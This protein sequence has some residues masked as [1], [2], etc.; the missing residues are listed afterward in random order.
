MGCRDV[1]VGRRGVGPAE[2]KSTSQR[3]SDFCPGDVPFRLERPV[4]IAD[5]ERLMIHRVGGRRSWLR[6]GRRSWLRSGCRN[7][8]RSWLGSGLRPG[9]WHRSRNGTGIERDCG[10]CECS[11]I[12]YRTG[13]HRNEGLI[14]YISIKDRCRSKC[15][16]A[17]DLPEDVAGLGTAAQENL[18]GG[19]DIE[20]LPYLEDPDI[21]CATRKG[22]IRWYGN[23]GAPLI[24]ARGE[25]HPTNITSTQFDNRSGRCHSGSSGVRGFHVTYSRRHVSWS[26][27]SI[28]G[29]ICF[30][31]HQS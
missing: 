9:S 10:L 25:C 1:R 22:D 27:R 23:P 15:R 16:L 29:C 19:A 5:E 4:W 6:S 7:W 24:D 26:R 28:V 30:S 12:Q 31:S 20:R 18:L 14:Q 3:C 11:A 13:L 2:S 8:C 21:I 17:G